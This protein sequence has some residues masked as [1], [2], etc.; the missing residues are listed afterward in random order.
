MKRIKM[1]FIWLHWKLFIDIQTCTC[2]H[3]GKICSD[4]ALEYKEYLASKYPNL[5][6]SRKGSTL[7]IRPLMSSFS[8]DKYK[9]KRREVMFEFFVLN[10][11]SNY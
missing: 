7:T 5:V 3:V 10:K 2:I 4:N 9:Q 6:Y 8:L 1:F 11:R